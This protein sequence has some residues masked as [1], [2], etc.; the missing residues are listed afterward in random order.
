MEA[1]VP[2]MIGVEGEALPPGDA[3]EHP[4]PVAFTGVLSVVFPWCFG[5]QTTW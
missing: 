3:L 5:H 1:L 2:D 4:L